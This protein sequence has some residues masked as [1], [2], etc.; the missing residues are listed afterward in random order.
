MVRKKDVTER[1]LDGSC[2]TRDERQLSAI[3]GQC[4]NPFSG[5]PSP[6]LYN[7]STG[8]AATLKTQQFL[9]GAIQIGSR[10]MNEFI[11]RCVENE[12]A[13]QQP[14]KKQAIST[15]ADEGIKISRRINGKI[16]EVKMERDM[17]GRL[18]MLSI[19]HKIDLKLVFGY[20]LAPVSLVFGHIDG[21]T[22]HTPKSTLMKALIGTSYSEQPN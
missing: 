22:T 1:E 4:T 5:T 17:V 20:P 3:I 8:K 18:L 12:H 15:F 16:K 14:I 13:F 6:V 19:K 21:S 9:L 7:L 10:A 11:Q 2:I